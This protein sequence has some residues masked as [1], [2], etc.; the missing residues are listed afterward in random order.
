MTDRLNPNNDLAMIG[1][2][3]SQ[4]GRSTLVMQGD[5]NLVLYR[6]GGKVRWATSTDGQTITQAI[7]QGDGNF[8]MYGPGGVYL[9]DTATDG[10]PGAYLVVQDDGNVVIYDPANN[11]LWATNTMIS[12]GMVAGFLPST[13]G[14]HFSNSTFPAVPDLTINILGQEILIGDASNGLC[15]GMVFAARD[16]FEAGISIPTD[17]TN[18]AAGPLFDYIVKRLFDS[19]NLML[20]PAPPPP[21]FITPTPPF[22]PGPLTYMHLMNPVLP[23]HETE[24]SKVGLAYR[25]RAWIM[26]NDEWPKIKADI[27][28]SRL[29]PVAL[30]EVKSIDPSQLGNNH[31]VLA[32]GYDLDGAALT[33]RLYD[34]NEPDNDTVTMSLSLAEP[35]HTT[36]VT[37][38]VVAMV[39]CFFQPVYTFSRPSFNVVWELLGGALTS[40]PA[41]CS[42]AAG[43]L[44]VFARATDN[45]LWHLSYDGGWGMWEQLGTNQIS[46]D[47]ASVAWGPNRIDVFV[48]GTDNAL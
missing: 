29:S 10:H 4:N 32:Y 21:V 28:N 34:P 41:V 31:Q 39:L 23:D 42:W 6:T 3:T 48:R 12:R 33:I 13:S 8:V 1:S 22:G 2:I 37:N 16:Y 24:F 36:L 35:E 40:D 43:R 27:D 44:D 9:W 14:F 25:G 47:P 30:V 5:G 45:A 17:T 38:S 11:P 20:I 19:F 26:I 15:G 7:M 46:S 18:P